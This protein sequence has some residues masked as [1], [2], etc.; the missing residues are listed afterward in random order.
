MRRTAPNQGKKKHEVSQYL[1]RV[2]SGHP[3]QYLPPCNEGAGEMEHGEVGVHS[4]LPSDQHTAEPVHPAVGSFDDPA[5][6]PEASLLLDGL[7]L[8]PSGA[9]VGREAEVP[10]Q[11]PNFIKVVALVQAQALGVS[12]VGWGRSTGMLSRV[13]LT[14]FMSCRLAPS[15]ASPTG[16]PEPSVNRLRFAPCLPRSVGF[17]LRLPCLPASTGGPVFLFRPGVPCS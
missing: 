15:T 13:G 12:G 4:F 9:D 8:L 3:R 1:P 14:S 2:P 5:P 10:G 6:G 16:I 17:V 11:I 7:G